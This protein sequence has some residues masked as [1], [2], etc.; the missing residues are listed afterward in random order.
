MKKFK[1]LI[2]PFL[3]LVVLASCD[4][5]VSMETTVD[6]NGKLDKV[7][8]FHSKDS[9]RNILGINATT[10][11]KRTVDMELSKISGKDTKWNITWKKTFNSSVEA[12]AELAAP[13]DT[14]FRVTSTFE[15]KFRW[16]YTYIYYADTYHAINRMKVPIGDYVTREDYAFIDRLPAEGQK[17]SKADSV[18]LAH[19]NKKLFD[20]YGLRAIYED[21]FALHVQ[22]MK[23]K[24][25]ESR[26]IDTLQHHKESIF[27]RI[28]NDKNVSDNFLLEVMDSLHIPLAYPELRNQYKVIIKP[29][30]SR[31]DFISMSNEGKYSHKINMPWNVVRTNADSVVNNQL[32]WRPPVIKFLIKDYTMYGEAR[33]LNVWAIVGSVLVIGLTV[34]VFTRKRKV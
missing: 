30:T 31:M 14:L 13:S 11:W 6:A 2:I 20:I 3:A 12:N 15:K 32:F 27:Q 4:H 21:Y 24:N 33:Q 29:A 16:F 25:V 22:L 18:Y 28:E 10:G 17:I 5:D 1:K 26:W 23:D 8:T 7:M 34:F 19:L 9:T